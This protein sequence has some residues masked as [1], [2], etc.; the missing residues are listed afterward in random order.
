MF[1]N[2]YEDKPVGFDSL[3]EQKEAMGYKDGT[4]ILFGKGLT[5][6]TQIQAVFNEYDATK[7]YAVNYVVT[8]GGKLYASNQ[9]ISTA[10]EWTPAHWTELT[11]LDRKSVV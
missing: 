10:E 11:S 6:E 7:T 5:G 2:Y 9:A 8:K 4:Y 3:T 1:N